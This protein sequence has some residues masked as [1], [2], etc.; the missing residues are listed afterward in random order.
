MCRRDRAKW[1][2]SGS[3]RDPMPAK[4][5]L[6]A[7][8]ILPR[9]AAPWGRCEH[10]RGVGPL[11]TRRDLNPHA[12]VGT[13]P[14]YG[15][16]TAA[17]RCNLSPCW[18]ALYVVTRSDTSGRKF[19]CRYCT[20]LHGRRSRDLRH[21]P[22]PHRPPLERAGV[23]PHALQIPVRQGRLEA[24]LTDCAAG[25]ELPGRSPYSARWPMMN[26]SVPVPAQAA[27]A[28]HSGRAR[29]PASTA[30]GSCGSGVSGVVISQPSNA[31]F[32]DSEGTAG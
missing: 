15:T 30:E 23:A 25:A 10:G 6:G 31:S 29:R 8:R 2:G 12:L 4:P 13:R 3:P 11:V 32:I 27:R 16:D 28:C 18:S 17:T 9:A 21:H 19:S 5:A 26:A 20:L 1:P 22:T 24:L 7:G 14:Q